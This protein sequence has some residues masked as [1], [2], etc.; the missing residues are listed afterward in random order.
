MVGDHEKPKQPST[1]IGNIVGHVSLFSQMLSLVDR[2]R[3][4]RLVREHKAEEPRGSS[5][6][7]SLR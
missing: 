7:T 1:E 4:E 5:V 2:L 3:F 6:G